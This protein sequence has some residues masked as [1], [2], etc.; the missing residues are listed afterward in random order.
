MFQA[1]YEDEKME[2]D[3]ENHR[4]VLKGSYFEEQTGIKLSDILEQGFSQHPEKLERQLL[5][6]IS[7]EIYNWV[8]EHNANNELQAEVMAF[9]QDFRKNLVRALVAQVQYE[10]QNGSLINFANVNLKTGRT[11]KVNDLYQWV[12]SPM[13]KSLLDRKLNDFGGYAITYQGQFR[14]FNLNLTGEW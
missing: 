12:I 4:Y 7:D 13:A 2:Y 6:Q 14:V 5:I 1:P 10:I 8:F 11:G 9:S 3:I